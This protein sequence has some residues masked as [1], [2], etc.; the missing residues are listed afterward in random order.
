[1]HCPLDA[2]HSRCASV[3]WRH[4]FRH[5]QHQRQQQ[6]PHTCDTKCGRGCC[7]PG[8]AG[9]APVTAGCSARPSVASRAGA[10]DQALKGRLPQAGQEV[11]WER[12]VVGQGRRYRVGRAAVVWEKALKGQLP[13]V[14]QKGGQE[15][16][17]EEWPLG[18]IE[19]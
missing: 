7:K 18:E 16:G 11:G 4:A 2:M 13:Q 12:A 1:M 9:C 10:W 17:W 6:Q 5:P 8:A 3:A 14:M 15:L 19:L